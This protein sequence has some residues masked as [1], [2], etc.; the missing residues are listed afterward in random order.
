MTDIP[1]NESRI[2]HNVT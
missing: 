1:S 2:S